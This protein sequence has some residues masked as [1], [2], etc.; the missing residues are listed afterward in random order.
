VRRKAGWTTMIC[1]KCKKRC[2]FYQEQVSIKDGKIDVE[3][4]CLECHQKQRLEK[5]RI[6]K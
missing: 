1:D 6:H 3:K 2:L 5:W 4:I